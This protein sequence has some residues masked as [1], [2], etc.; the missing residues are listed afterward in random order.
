MSQYGVPVGQPISNYSNLGSGSAV[1]VATGPR[2]IRR[3]LGGNG[4]A[5][6]YY[7]Q[8]FDAASAPSNGTAPLLSIPVGIGIASSPTENDRLFDPN[9]LPVA[10]GIFVAWSST[11]ATYTGAA[12]ANQLIEVDFV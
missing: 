3:I 4:T 11:F 5:T 1:S 8:A 7:L 10:N 12:P 2:Q 6:L 9:W